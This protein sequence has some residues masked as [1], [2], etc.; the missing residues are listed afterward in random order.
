M[1]PVPS[2]S[3]GPG[4]LRPLLIVGLTLVPVLIAADLTDRP[5]PTP[6]F[7]DGR[8]VLLGSDVT[9]G[10]AIRTLGLRA[11][12]GRLLDVN[13]GV[14]D[15]HADPGSILLNGARA[16]RRTSLDDGDRIQVVDGRNRTEG[17]RTTRTMLRGRGPGDP[18]FTLGTSRV[19]Q[20]TRAG[21][22]SGEE[23]STSYRSV[24][25]VDRPPQVALT[26]DDGPWPSST[27]AIL[28]ELRRLHV[29]ATFFMVGYLVQRYPRIVHDVIRAGMA[30][31]D[32]SWSH[33]YRTPFRE[34]PER[35]IE[36]EIVRPAHLLRER[37]GVRL[38][39]FRPP[40]GSYNTEVVDTARSAG[41]RLVNWN[42][43]PQDY[44]PGTTASRIVRSVLG[45]VEPGSIVLMHDGGGDRSATVKAVP[46]I[47]HGIRR[48]GL[49]LVAIRV[50][51]P[52][53]S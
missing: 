4:V 48:M 33:P 24:G 47:V 3:R 17:I 6:V 38:T 28:A 36:T 15:P 25:K 51:P 22:I 12:P 11:K 16:T 27:E 53:A 29:P 39:L 49:K 7:V 19:L 13:G 42:V 14:L 44:R 20:V 30:I 18:M 26:F 9:L 40:A 32:H 10:D 21:R 46:R 34:L 41:L 23:V 8:L 43:D 5:P 31:G 45:A 52:P 2:R 35:R 1:A 50:A 37:F